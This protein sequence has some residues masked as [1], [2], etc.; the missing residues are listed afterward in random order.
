MQPPRHYF[1]EEYGG[2][3]EERIARRRWSVQGHRGGGCTNKRCQLAAQQPRRRIYNDVCAWTGGLICG[4]LHNSR[5]VAIMMPPAVE[6][7]PRRLHPRKLTCREAPARQIRA[8]HEGAD[9]RLPAIL[10]DSK[11]RQSFLGEGGCEPKNHTEPQIAIGTACGD[12]LSDL[13]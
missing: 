1:A 6:S 5:D 12:V 7:L 2:G 4:R 13:A 9:T 8:L 3:G 10:L 11:P